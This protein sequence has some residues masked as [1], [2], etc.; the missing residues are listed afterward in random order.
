MV[1]GTAGPSVAP[2]QAS[3]S[4]VIVR[5]NAQRI[6]VVFMGDDGSTRRAVAAGLRSSTLDRL[7]LH[8]GVGERGS[9][10]FMKSTSGT[11]STQSTAKTW[12]TSM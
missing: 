11:M 10:F 4:A 2:P 3:S 6:F 12:I 1:P 8:A 7:G 5:G 9:F